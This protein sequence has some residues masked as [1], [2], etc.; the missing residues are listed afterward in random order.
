[1]DVVALDKSHLIP[2]WTQDFK[3]RLGIWGQLSA[4][5]TVWKR[6]GIKGLQRIRES[7]GIFR[8]EHMGY[9]LIAGRNP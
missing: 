4:F 8:S 6:W 1:M 3:R 2:G 9:G 5:F 7:E